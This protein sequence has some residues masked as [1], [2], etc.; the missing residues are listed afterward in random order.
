MNALYRLMFFLMAP[1]MLFAAGWLW[2]VGGGWWVYAASGFLSCGGL[3]FMIMP[4]EDAYSSGEN[5]E[6]GR[7]RP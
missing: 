5:D 7:G 2:H 1:V 6:Q 4:I 3:L